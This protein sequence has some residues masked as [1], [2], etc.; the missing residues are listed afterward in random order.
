MS[1]SNT[2]GTT[3]PAPSF[4]KLDSTNYHNWA[5]DIQALL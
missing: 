3:V 4:P 5:Y 1:N 2:E